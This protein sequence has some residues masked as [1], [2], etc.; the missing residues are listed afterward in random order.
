M[1]LHT[2]K[3]MSVEEF[4]G[5]SQNQ[6]GQR[7]ELINGRPELMSPENLRHVVTKAAVWQAL[8]RAAKSAQVKLQVLA[9]GMTVRID[10]RTAY[11]PDAMIYTGDPLPGDTVVVPAPLVVVEV[12]SPGS[13]AT[14]TGAKLK[15]YFKVA[16]IVHYLIIDADD[17]SVTHHRRTGAEVIET[18]VLREGVLV[19]DRP[20]LEVAISEFFT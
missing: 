15:G 13:R 19:L 5:W 10:D 14:D 1:N 16:S 11:E 2:P 20:G 9:D 18:R 8:T 4:I 7:F 17:K 3:P 12:L 6:P